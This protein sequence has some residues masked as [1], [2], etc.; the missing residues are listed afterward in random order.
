M[1]A[2]G[3]GMAAGFSGASRLAGASAS[4]SPRTRSAWIGFASLDPRFAGC[5][6]AP[7]GDLDQPLFTAALRR[8]PA[9]IGGGFARRVE[10]LG[11]TG[12]PDALRNLRVEAL[13]TIAGRER[14]V[15][16]LATDESGRSAA[17]SYRVNEPHVRLAIDAGGIERSAVLSRR[18]LYAIAV[19]ARPRL[20]APLRLASYPSGEGFVLSVL[21]GD[22]AAA[23]PFLLV[24]I[25]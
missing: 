4:E 2:A 16:A 11:C 6:A 17:T 21:A 9:A 23:E 8:V 1:L 25:I 3:V 19:G 13:H 10:L 15:L 7:D 18:G 5:A 22:R 14:R 12:R 24:R 20:F